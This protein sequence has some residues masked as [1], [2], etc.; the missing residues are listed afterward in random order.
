MTTGSF[1]FNA[2]L[3]VLASGDC[4]T[5]IGFGGHC[6]YYNPTPLT[7]TQAN[8]SCHNDGAWLVEI[9]SY[10]EEA[11]VEGKSVQPLI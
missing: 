1:T 4:G 6:Y 2:S 11:F 8:E 7:Y 10:E 5:Y 3:S 9:G